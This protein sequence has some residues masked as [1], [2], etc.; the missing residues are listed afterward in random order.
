MPDDGFIQPQPF[1]ST[2]WSVIE[3]AGQEEGEGTL[4]AQYRVLQLYMPALQSY[5]IYALRYSPERAEDILHDFVTEKILE[6]NL[7]AGAD[8]KK[9]KFRSYVLKTLNNYVI[10]TERRKNTIKRKP[11]TALQLDEDMICGRDNA[12]TSPVDVFDLAWARKTIDEAIERTR[13]WCSV[14]KRK[15]MWRIFD[16]RILGPIMRNE[17]PLSY[18]ELVR[19]LDLESPTQAYNLLSS[20]KQMFERFLRSVIA[21][22]TS[23]EEELEAEIRELNR[24]LSMQP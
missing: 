13:I 9:G 23:G 4:K 24:V 10:T 17:A 22:Y 12:Q 2:R 20:S 5:L 19:Q 14:K 16:A 1:P 7:L 11:D 3:L 8:R 18:A 6:K 21:E 15:D